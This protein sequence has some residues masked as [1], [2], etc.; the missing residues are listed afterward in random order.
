MLDYIPKTSY[1]GY[2]VTSTPDVGYQGSTVK[3]LK[4][5]NQ[6]PPLAYLVII[7]NQN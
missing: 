7:P 1:Q 3:V 5:S 2:L 4:S 6:K